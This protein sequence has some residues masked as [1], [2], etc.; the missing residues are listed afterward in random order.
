MFLTFT[1]VFDSLK[2]V[3]KYAMHCGTLL[4]QHYHYNCVQTVYIFHS[5][6]IENT[7]SKSQTVLFI[8]DSIM[9][10]RLFSFYSL[11]YFDEGLCYDGVLKF[12][13]CFYRC[14]VFQY[15]KLRCILLSRRMLVPTGYLITLCSLLAMFQGKSFIAIGSIIFNILYLK[16]KTQRSM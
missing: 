9:K 5:F 1:V 13:D 4:W 10:I 3:D 12:Y 6:T 7:S 8:I 15:R 11:L 14:H 2:I 16:Y